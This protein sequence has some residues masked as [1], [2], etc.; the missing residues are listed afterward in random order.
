MAR[1]RGEEANMVFC[2]PYDNVDVVA[3]PGVHSHVYRQEH[4]GSSATIQPIK[5]SLDILYP[6]YKYDRLSMSNSTLISVVVGAL[7]ITPEKP[8]N[9]RFRVFQRQPALDVVAIISL[10]LDCSHHDHGQK[11]N[12]DRHDPNAVPLIKIG[13]VMRHRAVNISEMLERGR[14]FRLRPL[15]VHG[16]FR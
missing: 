4:H 15:T 8:V 3:A 5:F 2:H 14:S 10:G 12:Q 6:H 16:L 7:E 9:L 11:K 13:C 1:L